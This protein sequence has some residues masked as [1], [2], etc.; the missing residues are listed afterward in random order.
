MS[1]KVAEMSKKEFSELI[2]N[3][4]ERKLIELIGEPDEGLEI[5][6]T[7]RKRLLRQ[8]QAVQLG[9]RGEPLKM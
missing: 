2:E 8:K 6:S 3:L 5:R 4:I 7:V 9:E 1:T